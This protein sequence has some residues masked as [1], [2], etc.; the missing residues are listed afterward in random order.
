MSALRKAGVWLGLVEEED[1]DRS[2]DDGYE[3][4]GRYRESGYRDRDR[5]SRDGW[6]SRTSRYAEEFA[7]E[8]EELDEQPPPR[9]RSRLGE[10]VPLERSPSRS[11][12]SRES[13]RGTWTATVS[14]PASGR[15]PG[16]VRRSPSRTRLG[17]TL[18]SRPRCSSASARSWRTRTSGT[19]SR[20]ST[21][22]PI[23]KRGP[24]ANTSATVYQ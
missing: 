3:S 18:P 5:D 23:G 12:L 11:E 22:R 14:G 13:G 19:R 20:R 24:S 21:R 1:D 7:D 17:K 10:R 2:Y 15:S 8:D 4:K 9:T 6:E 16:R